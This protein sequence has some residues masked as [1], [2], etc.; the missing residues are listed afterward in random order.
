MT[1]RRND[2]VAHRAGKDRDVL[3]SNAG[4][5]DD[6]TCFGDVGLDGIDHVLF[7]AK[8]TQ[9]TTD[10]LVDDLH[11]AAADQLLHL[12][13]AQVGLDSRGVAVH[14][15]TDGAS[16]GQHGGLGVADAILSRPD[17]GVVPRCVRC[18]QELFWDERG[19]DVVDGRP[20][21]SE[22]SLDVV[23]VVGVALERTNPSSE[24]S[25][26]VVRRATHDRRHRPRERTATIGVIR[27]AGCHE[28]R[29]E[30]CIAEAE[31]AELAGV[32]AN[33]PRGI[34]GGSDQDLLGSDSN[35]DSS[36]K[37]IC[38]ERTPRFLGSME[39]EEVQAGEIAG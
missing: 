34:V 31:L 2:V 30:V 39:C 12:D 23:G 10:T 33:G 26:H 6:R 3:V 37:L 1:R 9:G 4:S 14:E 19:V 20:V 27:G 38:F 24:T 7:V 16:R 18:A 17:A 35:V 29:T 21:L 36:D 15:E 25:R 5:A 32:V 22:H 13:Q 11:G 28:Q 8:L